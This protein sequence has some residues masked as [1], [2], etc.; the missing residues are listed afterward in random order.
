MKQVHFLFVAMALMLVPGLLHIHAHEPLATDGLSGKPEEQGQV[1]VYL[2]SA[3]RVHDFG[4]F[5]LEIANQAVGDGVRIVIDPGVRYQEMDGFGA[6]ISGSTAY[7]LMQMTPQDRTKFLT[8]T[9]C[10]KRGMG[11]SYVRISIGCSDF[12]LSEYSLCDNPGIENFALQ[13]EELTYVIPI[14]K[15]ILA[16]NPTLKIMGSPW[17]PPRWMKVDNL[18]D[19]GPHYEWTGGHLDP[20][21]Y[22]DYAIYFAKWIEAL[23]EHGISIHSITPQN[24]PL[25]R[26]NSASLFMGWEEQRE[27]VKVLGKSLRDAG[28]DTKIYVFDHNYNY[29]RMRDQANYPIKIYEDAEAKQY[30][31]GAAYHNY[32]GNKRELLHIHEQAPDMELIFTETSIGTWNNG[33]D[34]SARLTDDMREIAIGTVNNWCRGVIVWNLMLDFDRGP[35]RPLGC[36]TCFGSVDID[37]TD[38]KTI[39]RNSHYYI[40]GHMAAVV[41][42]GAM[43]IKAEGNNDEGMHFSAFENTDGSYALVLANE[44]PESISISVGDGSLG[45]SGKVP[46]KSVVSYRW[47]K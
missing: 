39:V 35:N 34:L 45:F 46:A 32:G 20:R 33:R 41:K 27:F 43:R 15:E 47:R 21:L 30:V 26:G 14:L 31:A 3:D 10:H 16:I 44:N 40:I 2:T 36:R 42:P 38:Y 4:R 24:E 9:F 1:T 28:L 17:T 13:E 19:L 5:S 7:N 11:Y 25:H 37:Q 18:K 12:S 6:A 22:G 23:A 8:E 29:D